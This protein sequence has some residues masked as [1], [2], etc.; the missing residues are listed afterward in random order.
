MSI[1]SRSLTALVLT[2]SVAATVA[3]TTNGATAE[4]APAT[5]ACLGDWKA[6][7]SCPAGARV[8]G[9]ECRA[10]EPQRGQGAG[11]HW[12]G[13]KRQGPAL[14][15]R[16]DQ[17]V[18]FAAYYRDHQKQGRVFHFAPDGTLESWSDM[19]ADDYHGLS[20]TCLPDGRVHYLAY[21]DHGRVVGVAR[22]WR[23]SDGALS[24]VID[25]GRGDQTR[26]LDKTAAW[27]T[28]PDALCRPVRCDVTATPDLSGIPR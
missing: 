27:A 4:P 6:F 12:S 8:S 10:R 2:A 20:V 28:R 11:E 1:L 14:F 18:S 9:T 13:S 3:V 15:L 19:A 22:S 23:A 26:I 16:D 21:Y 5:Q 7:L 25:H 24:S 17:H